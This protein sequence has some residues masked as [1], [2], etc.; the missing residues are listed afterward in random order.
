[1]QVSSLDPLWKVVMT[2]ASLGWLEGGERKFDIVIEKVELVVL[3]KM[4]VK[5]TKLLLDVPLQK[6]P[7]PVVYFN[8]K[9]RLNRSSSM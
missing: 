2:I 4:L 9:L 1:M 5:V 6:V 3:E 7:E 8:C